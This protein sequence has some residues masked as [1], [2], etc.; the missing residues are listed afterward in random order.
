MS[1]AGRYLAVMGL[2]TALLL[3][4]LALFNWAVDP[5]GIYPETLVSGRNDH[6]PGQRGHDRMVKAHVI[7]Q[8]HPDALLLGTSRVQY[9]FDGN[10]PALRPHAERPYNAALLG[11]N[12]Y[13][14]LRYLQH[15]QAQAP[16]RLAIVGLDSLM[17]DIHDGDTLRDF[18]EARLAVDAAGRPTKALLPVDLATTL[19][20]YDA[21]RLSLRSIRQQDSIISDLLPSGQRSPL[22]LARLFAS[23]G[24]LAAR[25]RGV[26]GT[27][28]RDFGQAHFRDKA[29][30]S[31]ALNDLRH[32]VAFARAQGIALKL[33]L[34][35][36]HA[37]MNEV[38]RLAGRESEV[39]QLKRAL[40]AEIATAAEGGGP[41]PA[42]ELWDFSDA[43]AYTTETV[44]T[45]A[46]AELR[47][48]FETTHFRPELGHLILRR[49]LDGDTDVP[50]L[51]G[52]GQRLTSAHLDQVLRQMQAS[53]QSY[54]DTHPEDLAQIAQLAVETSR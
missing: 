22:A 20:S 45:A 24:S 11:S 50:E 28:L 40:V 43:N 51:R 54:R 41:G 23:Q 38:I 30:G 17:F 48:Y 14:A 29:G 4:G 16:V 33:F 6:K 47:W 21:L 35:P 9:G 1:H 44:P 2:T 25:M 10:D 5:Y 8:L 7:D 3:G 13:L 19:L 12:V 34:P 39:T 27:Y 32:L 46:T 36:A 37:R 15:A 52:F 26:E 31:F 49:M 42:V 53:Q 18:S